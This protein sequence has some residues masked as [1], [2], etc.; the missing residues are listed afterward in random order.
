VSTLKIHVDFEAILEREHLRDWRTRGVYINLGGNPVATARVG[1][2]WVD[3]RATASWRAGDR[4][5][6]ACDL[7]GNAASKR[8]AQI[9]EWLIL[10]EYRYRM[11][12]LPRRNLQSG[13]STIVGRCLRRRDRVR[14][15]INGYSPLT[16]RKLS[17]PIHAV[18]ERDARDLVWLWG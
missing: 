4:R 7:G 17:T 6:I 1:E 16:G 3:A 8:D 14:V 2:G 12:R 5:M 10:E 18:V 9:V 15:S 13:K 11:G